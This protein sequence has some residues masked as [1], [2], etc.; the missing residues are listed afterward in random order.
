MWWCRYRRVL[1]A[2][3]QEADFPIIKVNAFRLHATGA[4]VQVCK[5]ASLANHGRL[6]GEV[7]GGTM[8]RAAPVAQHD[9]ACA[10]VR[11]MER[12]TSL[13]HAGCRLYIA[14]QQANTAP[15]LIQAQGQRQGQGTWHR[16]QAQV[17][18]GSRQPCSVPIPTLGT[19]AESYGACWV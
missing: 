15:R 7:A 16:A 6:V 14:W 4:S 19:A 11:V 3:V 2:L 13:Y 17:Q 12:T 8:T 5:C 18:R 1:T 9:R 10:C